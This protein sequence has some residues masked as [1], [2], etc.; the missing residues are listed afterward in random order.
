MLRPCKESKERSQKWTWAYFADIHFL[1]H[2]LYCTTCIKYCCNPKWLNLWL[3]TKLTFTR[4]F[5]CYQP[6][7]FWIS[8]CTLFKFQNFKKGSSQSSVS[9]T[10][11]QFRKES[12]ILWHGT[13]AYFGYHV[14]LDTSLYSWSYNHGQLSET[15]CW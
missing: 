9:F 15:F 5:K 11:W 13:V 14:R 10:T 6:S 8:L 3:W 7:N 12:V 2:T 4:S 1:W